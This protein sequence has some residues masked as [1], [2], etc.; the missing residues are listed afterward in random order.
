MIIEKCIRDI[1]QMNSDPARMW[2]I[3]ASWEANGRD[4]G[5]APKLKG[6][7]WFSFAEIKKVTNNFS[8][9]NEIGTGGYGKV[10]IE[11]PEVILLSIYTMIK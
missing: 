2:T 8:D 1:I 11:M 4:S 3:T 10:N 6:A 7:R 5:G 9:S